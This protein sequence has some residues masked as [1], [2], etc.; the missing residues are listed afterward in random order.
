MAETKSIKIESDGEDNNSRESQ[1]SNGD[2][3]FETEP[4]EEIEEIEEIGIDYEAELEA[5]KKE[6]K[7]N[8]DRVLRISAEFENYKKRTAREQI[9][10]K[11]YSNEALIKDL[12]SVVDNLERAVASAENE[13][14]DVSTFLE[15]VELTCQDILKILKK[16]HVNPIEAI[17]NPFDPSYHQAVMQTETSDHPANTVIQELQKGYLIY[18]RLL[19]PAMVAVSKSPNTADK[20]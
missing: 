13:S 5:A 18:D 3:E 10:F 17:G 19:R 4:I 16:Y 14:Q 1:V 15:G 7:E 8:Y 11:K 12:L 6:A 20:A 2:G 9:E